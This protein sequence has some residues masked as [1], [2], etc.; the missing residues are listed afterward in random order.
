MPNKIKIKIQNQAKKG[1]NYFLNLYMPQF[2]AFY[3]C[4]M[5]HCPFFE[6]N[7]PNSQLYKGP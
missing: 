4:K 7:G 3:F 5:A 6:P 1:L 2:N